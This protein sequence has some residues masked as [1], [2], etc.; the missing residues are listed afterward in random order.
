MAYLLVVIGNDAAAPDWFGERLHFV[1]TGLD[2]VVHAEWRPEE[3]HRLSSSLPHGLPGRF[4]S[5][6]RL[7]AFCP[8]MTLSIYRLLCGATHTMRSHKNFGLA[9]VAIRHQAVARDA[10]VGRARLEHF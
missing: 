4:T 3:L 2:P 9:T 1:T 5:R 6:R 8:A 7:R 10:Q